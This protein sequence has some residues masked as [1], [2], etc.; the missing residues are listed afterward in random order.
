LR[1]TIP[2][3]W[4]IK[5]VTSQIIPPGFPSASPSEWY[6]LNK[7]EN[8]QGITLSMNICKIKERM[9]R[10]RP[11]RNR[12]ITKRVQLHSWKETCIKVPWLVS[13]VK[14]LV[15]I[16]CGK[17]APMLGVFLTLLEAE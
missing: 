4:R 16:L 17:D 3:Y 6:G 5:P 10:G 9:D 13:V 15:T 7:K 12:P 14:S 1:A 2:P 8:R 11:P